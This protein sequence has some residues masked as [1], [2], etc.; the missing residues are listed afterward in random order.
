MDDYIEV[1]IDV[2]EHTDQ[3]AMLRKTL[4]ITALIDEIL[5][6]FDDISADSPGK[7]AVFLKGIDRPLTASSTL[8]Q[9]DIQ[10]QDELVFN[11]GKQSI[12]QMLNPAFFA[13]LRDESLDR[14]YQIQWQPALIGRPTNDPDHNILLAVNL[15]QHPKG[16]TVSRKHARI[17]FVGGNFYIEPL[18]DNNPI[19]VNGRQVPVNTLKEIHKGD[20]ITVGRE[21]LQL[22]FNIQSENSSSPIAEVRPVPLGQ[23]GNSEP[24]EPPL[25]TV[26]K[27]VVQAPV[28]VIQR[29]QASAPGQVRLLVERSLMA[30]KIGQSL[31]IS[32]YPFL[33]GRDLP[34]LA[35]E[36]EISRRHAEISY[37]PLTNKYFITDLQSTNGVSLDGTRIDP[38]RPYEI[39][40]GA[41]LGFGLNFLCRI[42]LG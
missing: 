29:V 10:P 12:R 37:D 28:A 22:T 6:E 41:R 38:N 30:V 3:R 11:Y 40:P 39:Y 13:F 42:D 15:Q 35:G 26:P 23:Y 34:L 32:S 21:N 2:F 25:P 17:S 8:T 5:K 14:I 1:K 20:H 16:Q 36:T 27:H 31:Q 24:V 18:T 4:T 19:A 7:Y 9:L 33:L